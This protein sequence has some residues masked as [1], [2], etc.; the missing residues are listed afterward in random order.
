MFPCIEIIQMHEVRYTDLVHLVPHTSF[1]ITCVF[2]ADWRNHDWWRPSHTIYHS[3]ITWYDKVLEKLREIMALK[4]TGHT[5]QYKK[6]DRKQK[7]SLFASFEHI[8]WIYPHFSKKRGRLEGKRGAA[9]S[10]ITLSH[11]TK[12]LN[13][14]LNHVF[15]FDWQILN[16][17][18]DHMCSFKSCYSCSI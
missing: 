3:T 6:W 18:G 15:S 10:E 5:C 11:S 16:S 2:R 17:G 8:Q 13:K 14:S 12:K 9:L 4:K 7:S 1:S